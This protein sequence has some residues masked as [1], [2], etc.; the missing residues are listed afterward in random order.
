MAFYRDK[1]DPDGSK[2]IHRSIF[3]NIYEPYTD[4]TLWIGVRFL[5]CVH[6]SDS[7]LLIGDSVD[8]LDENRRPKTKEHAYG[9][10][11]DDNYVLNNL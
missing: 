11:S 5:S 6:A 8:E 2:I 1:E 7:M 4:A 10:A 9:T 3:S